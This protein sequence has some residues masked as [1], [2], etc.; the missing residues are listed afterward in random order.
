MSNTKLSQECLFWPAWWRKAT[1][2]FLE[3]AGSWMEENAAVYGIFCARVWKKL[4][5]CASRLQIKVFR[6][7]FA[8]DTKF[9]N[10]QLFVCTGTKSCKVHG[11]CS[12]YDVFPTQSSALKGT[13]KTTI[14]E[15]TLLDTR[16]WL[17]FYRTGDPLPMCSSLL[18]LCPPVRA[19]LAK[20]REYEGV[21]DTSR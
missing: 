7:A 1:P 19:G 11:V 4:Q 15:D 16:G 6:S 18:L 20:R 9:C 21:V 17:L 3:V 5:Y 14:I 13:L 8:V 2:I 12:K 10:Y